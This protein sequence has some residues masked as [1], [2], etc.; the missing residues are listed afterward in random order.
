M[1]ALETKHCR[2]FSLIEIMVVLVILSVTVVF[3]TLGFQRLEN[4]RLET[5]AGQLSAWLQAV[6][7]DS[8]LDSAVYGVW[9]AE[10]QQTLRVGFFLD[11]RWWLVEKADVVPPTIE[12]DI[13]FDID[14]GGKWQPLATGAVANSQPQVLF[15][16]TG[17]TLPE[18]FQ[19]REGER[20]AR[21]ERNGDGVFEWSMW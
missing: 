14:Q 2:G 13:H 10:D 15:L 19:L 12:Q 17:M 9:M 5:Q 1:I 21:I 3:V 16:P 18:R 7:D 4:D 8:V 20:R 11:N 6:S